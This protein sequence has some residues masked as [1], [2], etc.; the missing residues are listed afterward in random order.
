MFVVVQKRPAGQRWM[1]KKS[2]KLEQKQI[3]EISYLLVTLSEHRAQ[4]PSRKLQSLFE[5]Y[6]Y[7]LLLTKELKPQLEAFSRLDEET[8]QKQLLAQTAAQIL[9]QAQIPLYQKS[10]CLV[11]Y[12]GRFYT[13]V[14]P[15]LWVCPQIKVLSANQR[16]YAALSQKLM[17]EFGASL[18]IADQP[19]KGARYAVVLE[20]DP[21]PL[22]NV[23]GDLLFSQE[24]PEAFSLGEI[25]LSPSLAAL[26]SGIDACSFLGALHQFDHRSLKG[27]YEVKSLLQNGREWP[28]EQVVHCLENRTLQQECNKKAEEARLTV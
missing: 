20:L 10:I 2:M 4:K 19:D 7:A 21:L 17:E 12:R 28:F 23:S 8:V 27:W 13:S 25:E 1:L 16:R 5:Q 18:A 22:M 26:P 9:Q 24:R 3:G 6:R 14:E 15:F 11:D